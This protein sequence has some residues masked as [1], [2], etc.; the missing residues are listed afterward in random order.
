MLLAHSRGRKG[1]SAVELAVLLPFLLFLFLIGTDFARVFYLKMAVD[2]CAQAGARWAADDNPAHR[3]ESGHADVTS[4]SLAAAPGLNPT[5]AVTMSGPAAVTSGGKSY[6]AY[7]VTVTLEFQPATRFVW[8]LFGI[9]D[10]VRLTKTVEIR[11][12]PT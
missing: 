10:S 7:Q 2:N 11:Q 12:L 1:A 9:P 3:R 4:A 5:P 8:S 6:P